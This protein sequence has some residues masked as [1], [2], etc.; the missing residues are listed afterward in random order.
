MDEDKI[1]VLE[2]K[3]NQ[4]ESRI[5][6]EILLRGAPNRNCLTI[7][8]AAAWIGV[9]PATV[10]KYEELGELPAAYKNAKRRYLR[11]DVEKY[12]LGFIPNKRTKSAK[13]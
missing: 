9:T 1:I 6:E 2:N 3:I 8:E 12:I 7:E 5:E 4:L 11:E 13:G 10:K